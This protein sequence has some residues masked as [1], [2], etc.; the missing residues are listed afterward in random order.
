MRIAIVAPLF[1]CVPP[2]QYGGTERVVHFIA[3]ELVRLGHT[4]TL[5]AAR[6]SKTS[7]Q[8]IECWNGTFRE[9]GIGDDAEE[10]R[11]PYTAQLKLV[12]SGKTPHDIVHIH[13]NTHA[14]HPAVLESIKTIPIVWT[15]HNAVH[16]DNKPVIFKSLA[17]LDIGL[18]A[19]SES[20]RSTVPDANWL[21]TI[22]H[23]LPANMLT[24]MRVAPT[25]LAFLGRIAPEKG[26]T[27]AVRISQGVGLK[28]KV[29]A[30]LDNINQAF[31]EKEVKPLF[32]TSE[33]D[34]IGEI[35]EAEKSPFLSAAIA[36]VFPICWLEPFGLVMIEAMACGCPVVAFRVGSVSEIVDHGVTGFVV[37]TEEEAIDALRQIKRLDR[38]RIRQ[39]FEERFTSSIMAKK[40][41]DVYERAIKQANALQEAK[42]LERASAIQVANLRKRPGLLSTDLRSLSFQGSFPL[43]HLHQPHSTGSASTLLTST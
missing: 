17:R 7:G 16:N 10:T 30:K 35:S 39:R 27:S 41:V 31:Y 37:D 14:Y 40:Y 34:F 12:M 28:L 23:G 5:Y 38:T 32:A 3:E 8:L 25:Y 4:V 18:T 22:H 36:L 6:G 19:L 21:A 29:A 43:Q 1:E 15:D 11:D 9:H 2:C 13:H 33:V 20:H 26:I 24:P 42:A